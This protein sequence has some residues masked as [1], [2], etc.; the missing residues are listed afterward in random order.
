MNIHLLTG[1]NSLGRVM[2]SDCQDVK[3]KESLEVFRRTKMNKEYSV[4]WTD[5]ATFFDTHD[6]SK[7][8]YK[9]TPCDFI[10]MNESA[11][12]HRQHAYI[13]DVSGTE[14][15]ISVLSHHDKLDTFSCDP[16]LGAVA[17]ALILDNENAVNK[18]F[19]EFRELNNK[20]L[21]SLLSSL[22]KDIDSYPSLSEKLI[23]EFDSAFFFWNNYDLNATVDGYQYDGLPN[24]KE[25]VEI[26]SK[27]NR[28]Y[29]VEDFKNA[30]TTI[31]NS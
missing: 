17:H 8:E 22:L 29:S 5:I 3:L 20:K 21:K 1:F 7:R 6:V 10:K 18:W 31:I 2:F 4:F 26:S 24:L 9:R 27:I 19:E 12:Q 28:K 23:H 13:K 25:L 11:G 16:C 14:Y 15:Q 30:A